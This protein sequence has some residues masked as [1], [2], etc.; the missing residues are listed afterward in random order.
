MTQCTITSFAPALDFQV[1]EDGACMIVPRRYLH[2]GPPR[3]KVDCVISWNLNVAGTAVAEAS[4]GSLAPAFY[5][6][7]PGAASIVQ[8]RARV[9]GPRADG[10]DRAD[11]G[12]RRREE[13]PD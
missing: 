2:G 13:A 1:V 5:G 3:P 9:L 12:H 8:D 6:A 10:E 11:A 4:I 7:A